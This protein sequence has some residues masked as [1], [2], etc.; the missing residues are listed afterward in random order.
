M[1]PENDCEMTRITSPPL[2]IR[3]RGEKNCDRGSSSETGPSAAVML[4]SFFEGAIDSVRINQSYAVLKLPQE[5]NESS[6]T[7]DSFGTSIQRLRELPGRM[8][9]RIRLRPRISPRIFFQKRSEDVS[10]ESLSDVSFDEGDTEVHYVE[11]TGESRSSG[12]A[13]LHE[14]IILRPVGI[15]DRLQSSPKSS[16]VRRPVPRHR[17][18]VLVSLES[19]PMSF[20]A[21]PGSEKP[22]IPSPGQSSAFEPKRR[23]EG[24]GRF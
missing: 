15:V 3:H 17:N 12:L 4:P 8:P 18:P 19:S 11:D 16:P 6:S 24:S 22:K 20:S 2:P 7:D 9:P 10:S 1:T 13:P 21:K 14:N 5:E 23:N